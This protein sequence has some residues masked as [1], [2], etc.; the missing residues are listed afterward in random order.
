MSRRER[1]KDSSFSLF[2]SLSSFFSNER[3]HGQEAPLTFSKVYTIQLEKSARTVD[4]MT[5]GEVI[6]LFAVYILVPIAR[7]NETLQLLRALL[8]LISL[9]PLLFPYTVLSLGRSEPEPSPLSKIRRVNYRTGNSSVCGKLR[10]CFNV[11]LK[12]HHSFL[13][14]ADAKSM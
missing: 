2:R 1:K 5:K 6:P 8:F 13:A 3:M 7:A 4:K 10:K 9:V 11:V 12:N 14:G